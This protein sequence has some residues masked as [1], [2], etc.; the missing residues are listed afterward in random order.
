MFD[1]HVHCSIIRGLCVMAKARVAK[2]LVKSIVICLSLQI[3]RDAHPVL[4]NGLVFLASMLWL[5]VKPCE[6]KRHPA[7]ADEDQRP[8]KKKAPA[9]P[10]EDEQEDKEEEEEEEGDVQTVHAVKTGPKLKVN[11]MRMSQCIKNHSSWVKCGRNGDSEWIYCV[12]CHVLDSWSRQQKHH[13]Q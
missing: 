6:D 9:T 5:S 7:K 10:P 1:I 8:R 11:I 13:F 4:V 3:C 12:Q 2:N